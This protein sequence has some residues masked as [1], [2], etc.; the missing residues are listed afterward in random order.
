MVKSR[1]KQRPPRTGQRSSCEHVWFRGRD[2]YTRGSQ[3][4]RHARVG[5]RLMV[6]RTST[7]AEGEEDGRLGGMVCQ[8]ARARRGRGGEQRA[9]RT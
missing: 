2:M 3:R 8:R 4:S 6:A 7:A 9:V 1:C 5:Q